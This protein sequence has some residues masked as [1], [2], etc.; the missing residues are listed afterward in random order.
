MA[1]MKIAVSGGAGFIASHIV[2][3]Y[4]DAG[5]DV[6]II[7][8]MSTGRS[9]NLNPSARCVVA[10]INDAAIH[11]LFRNES[12]DLLNHHAAQIDVRFSVKEPRRDAFTNIVGS[13]NLFEA[14]IH[15]GVKK[16]VFASSAGTVY[17]D[18]VVEFA[19]ETHPLR[20]LSPY[21]AAKLS[22]EQYLYALS[23]C[24]GISYTVLRYANVYGP[25]QNPH[26]EAGVVAIF[27]NK[28]LASE[29]PI[30]NGDGLQ[31]RDYV[32]VADV[33]QAN[34]LALNSELKGTY[35]V[36]SARETNVL[37]IL[38]LLNKATGL[39]VP[40]VHA[41]AKAGEQRR[42]CYSSELL[43]S[44]HGWT[45]SVDLEEGMKRTVEYER[46]H[47]ATAGGSK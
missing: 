8:N 3:A 18:Q 47:S 11:E 20:P 4:V 23:V 12:F 13:L 26:G 24:Y 44:K 46:Q 38:E 34:L 25:R 30:I 2:D 37:K 1:R 5:H 16:I 31:T 22:V 21:G 14:A 6:T 32:F 10:D 19:D 7:D 33:V 43:H 9:E 28:M 41:P 15:S 35:N 39:Q 45:P 29:Q 36:S 27:L 40:F 17:G 42:G